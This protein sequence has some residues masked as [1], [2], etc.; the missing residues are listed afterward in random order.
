MKCKN[1]LKEFTENYFIFSYVNDKRYYRKNKCK[2]CLGYKTIKPE[3]IKTTNIIE[4]DL[5]LIDITRVYDTTL[6][7]TSL[8]AFKLVNHHLNE[9]GYKETNIPIKEDLLNMYKDLIK[10]SNYN[11][12]QIIIHSI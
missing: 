1:C 3:T 11:G 2:I 7:I 5:F 9:F 6:Y 10:I 8:E 12:F 4:L